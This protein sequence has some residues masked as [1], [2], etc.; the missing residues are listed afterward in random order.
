M[1]K[2]SSL[3]HAR[4]ALALGALLFAPSTS[5]GQ[6]PER[7][8]VAATPHFAYSDL[9]TNLNDALIA[10]GAARP[11][12]TPELFHAGAEV[13]CFDNLP[14]AERAAWDRAVDYYAEIVSPAGNFGREQM[15]LRHQLASLEGDRQN[16]E[17]R[18]FLQIAG[19]FRSTAAPAYEACRWAAQDTE[20]RRWIDE[21]IGRLAAHE[22]TIAGRL[23]QL[24]QTP[25]YGL[26]LPVDVVPAALRTGASSIILAPAGGHILVSSLDEGNQAAAALEIVFH[27]AS[28]TVAAGWRGD[29]HPGALE[30][31][32]E[33]LGVP[34]P[35][36]LW[37]VVLFYTTG[38]TVR[39]VLQE[40]G[41]SEYTPYL[42]GGLFERAWPEYQEPIERV[43]PAYLNGDRTLL[44]ATTELL[45]AL[46]L[47]S[48]RLVGA[49]DQP[50]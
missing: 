36:D 48:H 19:G 27:E 13:D 4:M 3:N 49:D 1:M 21:V 2:R 6:V 42:Y 34:L 41:E 9:A 25:W 18:R 28:H 26:P 40:A 33:A 16:A 12:Q 46:G 32:A 14:V 43:W 7:A 37:H 5:L 17:D 20:N 22:E 44:E 31:A 47:R 29:P 11:R 38:E 10:S 39:R 23:E 8:T 15:L 30:E 24:Y 50:E 35:R 45:Q